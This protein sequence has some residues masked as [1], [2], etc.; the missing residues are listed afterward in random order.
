MP[1]FFLNTT[2]ASMCGSCQ[3]SHTF[4]AAS[5]DIEFKGITE[6]TF[7]EVNFKSVWLHL[8]K[9]WPGNFRYQDLNVSY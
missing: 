9:H 2:V 5:S 6:F 8:K 7:E 3:N 1:A 4:S